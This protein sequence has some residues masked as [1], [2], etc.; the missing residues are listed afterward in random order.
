M[1]HDMG[2]ERGVGLQI[3]FQRTLG[4]GLELSFLV[5]VRYALKKWCHFMT[6]RKCA[7]TSSI[8]QGW[9]PL[10]ELPTWFAKIA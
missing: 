10:R 4:A 9:G 3:Q 7:M 5:S 8:Q 2:L 1:Q 6:Q